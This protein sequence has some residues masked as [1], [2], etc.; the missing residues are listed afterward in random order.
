MSLIGVFQ[1]LGTR[2]KLLVRRRRSNSRRF[3]LSG[4]C[5]IIRANQVLAATT[6]QFRN[7]IALYPNNSGGK[8]SIHVVIDKTAV[9]DSFGIGKNRRVVS[10]GRY[11]AF[12]MA[13]VAIPRTLFANILRLITELRRR[14][15]ANAAGGGLAGYVGM[16]LVSTKKQGRLRGRLE[17]GHFSERPGSVRITAPTSRRQRR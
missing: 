14:G 10:H 5:I 2:A 1:G 11:V 7:G 3:G 12:Q 13:E 17:V 9:L 8:K 6:L 15:L 4:L 16:G